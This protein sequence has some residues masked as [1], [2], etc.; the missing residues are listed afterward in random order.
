MKA[1]SKT[2]EK[3]ETA[4]Q[5]SKITAET[6][7]TKKHLQ[8]ARRETAKNYRKNCTKELGK[9]VGTEN[10]NGSELGN[11][12]MLSVLSSNYHI[13]LPFSSFSKAN[14]WEKWQKNVWLRNGKMP[15]CILCGKE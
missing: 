1:I 3:A 15:K 9:I 4:K 13:Y 10:N 5:I 2:P 14:K 6:Q 11:Q 8:I 12:Q 7:R